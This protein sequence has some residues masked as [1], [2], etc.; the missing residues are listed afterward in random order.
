MTNLDNIR[1]VFK[2]GM[3]LTS[4]IFL[5]SIYQPINAFNKLQFIF[6]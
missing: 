5:Q 1:Q 2:N 6:F 3:L 4:Y